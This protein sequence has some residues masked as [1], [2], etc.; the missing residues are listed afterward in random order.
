MG[1]PDGWDTVFGEA[2]RDDCLEYIE[3]ILDRPSSQEP[4]RRDGEEVVG[5]S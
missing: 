1:I 2:R 3:K 4:D 5:R